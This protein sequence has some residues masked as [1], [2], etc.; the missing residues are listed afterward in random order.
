M[1]RNTSI[2]VVAER[3]KVSPSTV[4]RVITGRGRIGQETVTAVRQAMKELGY[5]P[6][7]PGHRRGPKAGN[8]STRRT[9]RVALL[10]VGTPR[11]SLNAP[12]YLALLHAVES[13]LAAQNQVMV[14]RHLPDPEAGGAEILPQKVDG[15]LVF[16]RPDVPKFARAVQGLPCVRLMGAVEPD[17]WYD[18]VTYDNRLIGR[19]A[20]RY[21][22]DGGHRQVAHISFHRTDFWAERGAVFGEEMRG[23]GGSV[24]ELI[25]ESMM[26]VS[27]T[28]HTV[29]RQR[30]GLLVDQL[31]TAEPKPTAVFLAADTLAPV[32]YSVLQ[33]RGVRPGTDIA[34]V[35]C[36]N[37]RQLLDGLHPRP[38]TVDIHAD[39]VGRRAVEQLLYRLG[40]RHESSAT[41]LI[42]PTLVLP[43][44]EDGEGRDA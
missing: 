23:A 40:N 17:A 30:M 19:L 39:T 12:V 26:R 7:A 24:L 32:F 21:L 34:V 25:D 18:H 9:N 27:E 41:L 8:G 42:R 31:L 6:P 43:E 5:R 28:V 1:E 35:S 14:L 11:V 16:G 3:A 2:Y 22:G 33:A 15:V 10:A 37:E 29:D 4:S 13:A 38:A 36:N 20:A 44:A